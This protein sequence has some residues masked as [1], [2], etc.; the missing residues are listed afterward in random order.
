ME[1]SNN[2]IDTNPFNVIVDVNDDD[3]SL[4]IVM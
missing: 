4:L 2:N 1:C 3:L